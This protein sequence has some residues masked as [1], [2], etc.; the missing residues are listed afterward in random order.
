VTY[1][2]KNILTELRREKYIQRALR[3][4][5]RSLQIQGRV[6]AN[7]VAEVGPEARAALEVEVGAEEEEGDHQVIADL[8]P[9]QDQDPVHPRDLDLDL[10]EKIQRR[11]KEKDLQE[12]IIKRVERKRD[13]FI[14]MKMVTTMMRREIAIHMKKRKDMASLVKKC[15]IVITVNRRVTCTMIVPT[16]K[17]PRRRDIATSAERRLKC[18]SAEPAEFVILRSTGGRSV[19]TGSKD[20]IRCLRRNTTSFSTT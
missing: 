14:W 8:D 20:S 12:M 9:D 1:S 18:A 4:S 3:Q 10:E 13:I 5:L 11:R 17:F 16:D 7:H 19:P 2:E 6:V 15:M